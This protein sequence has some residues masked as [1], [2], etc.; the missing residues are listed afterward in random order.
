ML[1]VGRTAVPS[2]IMY[3]YC[4]RTSSLRVLQSGTGIGSFRY[5]PVTL[6]G[7]NKQVECYA[8]LDDGSELTLVDEELVEELQLPGDLRP[9]CLKWTGGTHRFESN[10]QSINMEIAGKE[11]KR[12]RL[13]DVRTVKELQLP[14][15]S[16]DMNYLKSEFGYLRNL[17]IDSYSEVRPRLLIGLT[18]ASIM[19]VRKSREGKMGEPIA[20]KTNLGWTVYGVRSKED[21][22]TSHIYHICNCSGP[23]ETKL[24]QIVKN[25]FSLDS[26]GVVKQEHTLLSRD[27]ERAVMLLEYSLRRQTIR[28]W[29]TLAVR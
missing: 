18:H 25:Y 28:N 3:Y 5:L 1:C 7:N 6:Y 27:D 24:H 17:S 26:L 15:Q 12:Y 19:L 23:E 13:Q 22:N 2:D 8:F 10:S 20:V 21:F 4:T 29:I 11:G 9:L 16:L 14:C